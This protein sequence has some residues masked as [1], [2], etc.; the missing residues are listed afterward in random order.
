MLGV[1]G[2]LNKGLQLGKDWAYNIIKMVGNYG[3]VYEKYMGRRPVNWRS[4]F[5]VPARPTRSGPKVA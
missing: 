4:A 2:D 5:R 3:E 1:E